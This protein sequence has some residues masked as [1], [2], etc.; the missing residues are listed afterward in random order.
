MF[1]SLWKFR[2]YAFGNCCVLNLYDISLIGLHHYSIL[3]YELKTNIKTDGK[4]RICSTQLSLW[5]PC[6]LFRCKEST[7]EFCGTILKTFWLDTYINN[8]CKQIAFYKSSYNS[9]S[10]FF[11]W[12]QNKRTSITL[13]KFWRS[14]PIWSMWQFLFLLI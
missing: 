14:K 3:M 8:K 10:L 1:I 5:E 7:S 6:Y 2:N 12:N 11:R 9:S 4:L 13:V